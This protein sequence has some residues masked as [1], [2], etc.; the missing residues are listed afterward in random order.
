MKK[1]PILLFFL[2]VYFL[3]PF[4][5]SAQIWSPITGL[6]S[7]AAMKAVHFTSISTGWVAGENGTIMKTLDGGVNWNLLNSGTSQTLRAIFFIDTNNGWACGDLGT[8]ITT[9]DGGANWTFQNSG[10]SNTLTG[11]EFV[12]STTGW[13]VGLNNTLIKTTTSGSTWTTQANQGGSMWGLSM[14]NATNGW[15]AGDYNSVQSSVRLLKTTNGNNWTAVYNSGVTTFNSFNDIH[16]SDANSGWVVGTNGV[17]RH[18]TDAGSTTWTAQTSGTTYELLS[19]DFIDNLNGYACGRQGII[20]HTTDGGANWFGQYSSYASGT[21]WEIDM[22]NATTGFAV[23]DF[24]ILKYTVS[25]PTQPLVLLQ[26]NGGEIFQIGTKRFIIW[27]AQN[28]VTNVKIEY[29]IDGGA[30]W[31]SVINSTPAANGSYAWSVPNNPS[32]NCKVRISN[33]SNSAINTISIAPFYIMNSPQGI[34]Y[35]VLTAATVSNTPSQ[36]IISWQNDSNALSYSIDRK[37]STETT[38]T[39]LASLSSNTLNYTDTNVSN[40]IIYEYRVIKTTPLVTG[41]GYVYSGIDIPAPD[42]RGTILVAINNTFT[43]NLTIELQQLT[44]DLV[45]DGWKIV[46]QDFP[47]TATDITVKNWVTS[48]Y[49][50]P[51]ANVQALLI[52]GHIAIPYS[53]NYAPDGHSERIGAQPAD[54]FYA[55][56][57]G[58][59]TDTSVTTINTGTIYTPNVPGDGKWDQN[60]IPSLAELQVGRIDMY[61]MTGATLSEINLIKQY[62]N[63]NHAFRYKIINPARKALL[64]PHLDGSIPSTSAV[65][66]RSFSPMVGFGNIDVVNTNGCGSNCNAFID[67]LENNSYLWT[68]MAGGGTDTSCAGS[69]FTSDYCFTRTLNTVFMQLYGSYFVEWAKGGLP[70]PNNLL[71]APLTNSGMPLATCWTGGGP[72]WY[73]HPMGLGETIGFATKLSQNN[74]TTYDPGNNQNLGGIHM[75]LMGDPSLRLHMVYPISNLTISAL[76]NNLQLDWLASND[77]NIVGYNIY[78]SD[79]ISGDFLRINTNPVTG[80]S[81]TDNAPSLN[82]TNLYMVRAIKLETASS[83]TY[84]NMSTGVFISSD[85]LNIQ[86]NTSNRQLYLF[87]NPVSKQLYFSESVQNFE[88]YSIYGQKVVSKTATAYSLNV[89]SFQEGVYYVKT[90]T[91]FIKFIVKH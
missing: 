4:S 87:P 31:L 74:T 23:G 22:I 39:N 2:I 55:D 24:G 70:V 91:T 73:F 28:S 71:R 68:Y 5:M 6:P 25:P 19:V 78:R 49:N 57:N 44:T 52:I 16:F 27:Q 45:G 58:N 47:A 17:I 82:G 61:N 77:S 10:T 50:I 86:D 80:L 69:V 59:W 20:L 42:S 62:L 37:L 8:L 51:N 46:F 85:A 81:F 32:V 3:L 43:P 1:N 66:W 56:I 33:A 67:A 76:Q 83:G 41:Y 75:A 88:V 64:N 90:D 26:P 65:G 12:S 11:I 7:S 15:S 14:I 9:T 40:G 53:G 54:V 36:I 18:T 60:G 72:R 13:A 84:Y 79:S 89:E 38:W 63:K 48:Q 35:S 34:D 29:S 30:N 21:L